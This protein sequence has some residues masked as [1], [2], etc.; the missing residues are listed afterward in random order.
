VASDGKGTRWKKKPKAPLCPKCGDSGEVMELTK[1][2]PRL[3][4]YEYRRVPCKCKA[5]VEGAKRIVDRVPP[6]PAPQP[7]KTGPGPRREDV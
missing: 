5:G 4:G 6:N 7:K 1:H 3:K 2:G